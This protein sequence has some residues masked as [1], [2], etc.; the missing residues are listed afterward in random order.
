MN[1]LSKKEKGFVKDIVKGET[2]TQAILNNYDT[3]NENVAGVMASQNL[4]KLK[5]Q[6][7]IK[8]IAE[9]IPDSL[10]V[11]KHLALL[12]KT[13]RKFNAEGQCTSEEIDAQAVG[14]GLEM[15]YK[16]KGTFAPDKTINLNI[17]VDSSDEIKELAKRLDAF[18]RT[19]TKDIRS[20]GV[21]SN[22]MGKEI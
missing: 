20:D 19:R 21:N 4:G 3:D 2:G 1:Q 22:A 14:K 12:N 6:N 10:L 11:E 7:A 8:S 5:I 9:Q 18:D 15:A 16:V 17:E 13:D